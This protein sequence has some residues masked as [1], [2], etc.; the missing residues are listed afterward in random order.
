MVLKTPQ[1]KFEEGGEASATASK[2][3]GTAARPSANQPATT[4]RA[5]PADSARRAGQTSSQGAGTSRLRPPVGS[6]AD[7]AAPKRAAFGP[8]NHVTGG[9]VT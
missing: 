3:G 8:G 4:G 7:R 5:G 9:E 6:M 2:T 1:R